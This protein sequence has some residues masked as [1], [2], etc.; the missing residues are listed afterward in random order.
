[1]IVNLFQHGAPSR[2]AST[3]TS[4][5]GSRPPSARRLALKEAND[6]HVRP[7]SARTGKNGTRDQQ[8]DQGP[9][10][11]NG[12]EQSDEQRP[13]TSRPNTARRA[14]LPRP[15]SLSVRFL[16]AARGCCPREEA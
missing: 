7:F 12:N 14:D 6:Q 11:W 9:A 8:Q 5:A 4:R 16:P 13:S 15:L 3:S 2:P 10:R 1:M